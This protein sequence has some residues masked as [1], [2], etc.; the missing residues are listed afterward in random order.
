VPAAEPDR[1]V[2]A[3]LDS[4]RRFVLALGGFA[5]ELAGGWL[6]VHEK[7]PVGR[8]NFVDAREVG[9]GRQSAFIEKA[10][11][12]YFQRALRPTFRLPTPAPTHLEQGLVGLG[13]RPRASPLRVLF[14]S[15][16]P[17]GPSSPAVEVRVAHA[18]ETEAV[19]SFWT[20]EKERPEFRAALDVAIHH[21]NPHE[22]LVPILASVDGTPASAALLFRYR[23]A[24]GIHLVSTRPWARG[25]GAA[26]ALVAHVL[27][28]RMFGAPVDFFMITDS[29][30][31]VTHLETLGFRS[32]HSFVEFAL[33]EGAELSFGPAPPPGP[34][35][36][37]PP[38]SR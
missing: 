12:T 6:V 2:E 19:A 3:A 1:D 7:I 37:R 32:V 30:V 33:P 36:W 35:R 16:R 4:E 17:A 34:P 38:R 25:R 27:R 15:H 5:L 13:F 22:E 11:D 26:T 10:L 14:E 23:R 20:H 29:A 8:F 9:A 21:P 24:A 18:D 28:T 31:G